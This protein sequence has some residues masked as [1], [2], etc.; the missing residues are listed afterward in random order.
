MITVGNWNL[1]FPLG[2][3]TLW[4]VTISV[5]SGTQT[6]NRV[7]DLPYNLK[8]DSIY[9]WVNSI[10]VYIQFDLAKELF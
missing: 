3:L 8:E 10:L 5:A 4:H 1:P 9:S 2:L 6:H 7:F